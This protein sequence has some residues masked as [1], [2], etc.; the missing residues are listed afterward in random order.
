MW[1]YLLWVMLWL[2]ESA[3]VCVSE[4][5]RDRERE[6]ERNPVEDK[7]YLCGNSKMWVCVWLWVG[8]CGC[9][10]SESVFLSAAGEPETLKVL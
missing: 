7:K 3:C 4:R 2:I 1:A 9:V 6:R 10:F 5:S 8:G